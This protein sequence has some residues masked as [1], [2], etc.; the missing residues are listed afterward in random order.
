MDTLSSTSIC[1]LSG[2]SYRQLD[3]WTRTGVVVPSTAEA[4]GSGTQRRWSVDQVRVLTLL[5]RLSG[6]GCQSEALRAAARAAELLPDEVWSA[7]VVVNLDGEIRPII[8]SDD[9]GWVINLARCNARTEA[10]RR[11][12]VAA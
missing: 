3:Y 1:R 8:G 11:E 7:R 4:H 6:R 10:L 9:D 5:V 2:A 12:L